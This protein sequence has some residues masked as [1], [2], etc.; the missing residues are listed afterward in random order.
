ML[1]GRGF[2]K[3][4]AGAEWVSARARAMPEARI[5]LVAATPDALLDAARDDLAFIPHPT[6]GKSDAHPSERV[7][8]RVDDLAGRLQSPASRPKRR[9]LTPS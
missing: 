7:W 5:A 9:W 1:A 4:R 8:L 2:G 6:S 3:T